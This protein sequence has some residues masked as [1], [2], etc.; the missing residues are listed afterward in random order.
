MFQNPA[1]FEVF[2]KRANNIE[3]TAKNSSDRFSFIAPSFGAVPYG[4]I[5]F[6]NA[7]LIVYISRPEFQDFYYPSYTTIT[8]ILGV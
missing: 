7:Y 2:A 6:K 8:G 5:L 3:N 4:S 1:A